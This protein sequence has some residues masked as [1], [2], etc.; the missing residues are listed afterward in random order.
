MPKP[1]IAALTTLAM[2]KMIIAYT[3]FIWVF[4]PM[5]PVFVLS[6][7]QKNMNENAEV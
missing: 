6:F 1:P 2:Y 5:C 4:L 7:I 3:G